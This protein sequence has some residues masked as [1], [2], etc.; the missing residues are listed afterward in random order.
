M[1][2]LPDKQFLQTDTLHCMLI[3]ITWTPFNTISDI[4]PMYIDI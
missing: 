2:G 1:H 3:A 4:Q